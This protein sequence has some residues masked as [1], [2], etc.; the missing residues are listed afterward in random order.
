MSHQPPVP[1][2]NQ[3]PYPL[4]PEPTPHSE[5]P[6]VVAKTP[7]RQQ[8]GDAASTGL[9][10]GLAVGLIA[11]GVGLAYALSDTGAKKNKK[12]KKSA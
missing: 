7:E 4:H 11:A 9:I 8:G 1:E 6:P 3:S 2:G 10:V 5:L 12:R